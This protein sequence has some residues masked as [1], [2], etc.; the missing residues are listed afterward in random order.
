MLFKGTTTRREATSI[1]KELKARGA[2]YNAS[3][4]YDRTNYYETL[5]ATDANL[6]FALQLE[7]DRFVNS[8]VRREDLLSEM[9][10]VRSE[11]EQGENSP[12]NILCQRMLA[13]A[14]EWHNY[15]RTV[16]CNRSD[17]A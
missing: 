15:G 11:F 6:E 16:M 8:L 1:P 7:A 10:V 4:Y 12:E 5:A 9:T 14:C 17:S 13:V 2:S 3:T